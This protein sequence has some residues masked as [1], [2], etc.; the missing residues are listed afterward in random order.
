MANWEPV[1]GLEVHCQL[2]TETKIFAPDPYSYGAPAN[3]QAGPVTLGLPGVLPT[4]NQRALRMAIMAGV[5]LECKIARVT[6]FDRKHY[7]Y[8]DLPKG[9]QISQYDMPYATA[10][11]V[12]FALKESGGDRTVRIHRIHMEED[13]GKLLHARS[14][15]QDLSYVDLNRA[16]AP[17]LEIVSE[18]DIRSSEE[19]YYYLQSLRQVLRA[20]DVTDANM[21]EGS[22]R[23]DANVSVRRGPDAA[24]G[25]RVEIKNLNSFKA[26]RA[27]IDYEIERQI[28]L[29]ESGGKVIQSTVLWDADRRQTRLMRTKEDAE[30]YRYFPEPDL[31]AF[32]IS[33]DT[34]EEIRAE[35]PELP[36]ARLQRYMKDFALPQYDADV[37]SREREIAEYFE[38]VTRLS[39]DPKKS[40]NW[41]KDEVLGILNKN[42]WRLEEFKVTAPR[43][44]RLIQLLN[45]GRI[46]GRMAKQVFEHIYQEDLDADQVVDKY[47]YRPVDAG[48]LPAI[49][50]K[51][52]AENQDSVQKIL[53]GNDRVKGHLVGQVMKATRGQAPPAEVN[54]LIDAMLEK[55]RG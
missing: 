20:I 32:A 44:G 23:C 33:E 35:M 49:V 9:Y 25:T 48:D 13:A 52:F 55:A 24:F 5:A 47:N 42:D 37:L 15:G 10:G 34:V 31:P 7:F 29:I 26:V 6:K 14:G 19:A 17:L 40:S 41:V 18:P 8:P 27:A 45:E 28:E 38:E 43:L 50:E 11:K 30:D 36:D 4:L 21:E 54:Q 1:I 16:G 53:A 3:S 2:K 51:V 22:L 46:T 39:G 12:S